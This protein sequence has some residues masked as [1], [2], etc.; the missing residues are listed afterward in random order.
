VDAALGF[1]GGYALHAVA[2]R[3]KTQPPEDTFSFYSRHHFLVTAHLA[4]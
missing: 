1:G 3:L 4:H 2:T